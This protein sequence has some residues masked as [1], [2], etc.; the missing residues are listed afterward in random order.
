MQTCDILD[1]LNI[2]CDIPSHLR[3]E[4]ALTW[5]QGQRLVKSADESWDTSQKPTVK[6]GRRYALVHG[7][8]KDGRY[9]D[10]LF[11]SVRLNWRDAVLGHASTG[12]VRR[13]TPRQS[14]SLTQEL[15][16]RPPVCRAIRLGTGSILYNDLVVWPNSESGGLPTLWA[17]TWKFHMG[18]GWSGVAKQWSDAGVP[19]TRIDCDIEEQ[20]YWHHD[21]L[22]KAGCNN[23][24]L[25]RQRKDPRWESLAAE[26]FADFTEADWSTWDSWRGQDERIKRW[27]YMSWVRT[28][29]YFHALTAAFEA[30]FPGINVSDANSQYAVP[31]QFPPNRHMPYGVGE[32][33]GN[34]GGAKLYQAKEFHELRSHVRAST[35]PIVCWTQMNPTNEWTF[36]PEGQAYLRHAILLAGELPIVVSVDDGMPPQAQCDILS[37]LLN[38]CDLATDCMLGKPLPPDPPNGERHIIT[39][40]DC[41][42]RIVA[43]VSWPAG[44]PLPS[45]ILDGWTMCRNVK[46]DAS[47]GIW[48]ERRG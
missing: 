22:L 34:I 17:D 31:W 35:T 2:V 14:G 12:D 11:E 13:F 37:G 30:E 36:S 28:H 45:G 44:G 10:N 48:M 23:A 20:K 39:K 46:T 33:V 4:G 42:N 32:L 24:W 25:Q 3:P 16:L 7:R 5:L 38:E 19:F 6:H 41:G 1:R 8:L 9:K 29:R 26:F 15:M 47:R 21:R 18:E 43:Y 27:R 40:I